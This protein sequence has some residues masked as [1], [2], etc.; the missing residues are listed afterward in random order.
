MS[1][2][3]N[4]AHDGRDI[5]IVID[6]EEQRIKM[7]KEARTWLTLLATVAA[8]VTYQAGLNPPS[9][10]WQADD[11][12]GHHAGNPVLRDEHWLRY[13]TFYYFNTTAFVTSLAMI[14]VLVSDRFF[15]RK[16]KV[17][18][19]GITGCIDV[20]SLIGAY[21][22]GSTLSNTSTIFIIIITCVAFVP[23]IYIGEALPNL[24]Y[25]VMF[26]APPLFWL[27]KKGWLP[28]TDHMKR[29]VEMAKKRERDE[30]DKQ[31]EA[32]ARRRRCYCCAWGRAYK[33][34][35][36]EGTGQEAA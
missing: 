13:Q 33:Y 7:I 17:Y 12:Q 34:D 25:V 23:I 6:A 18:T 4:E 14:V 20:A 5:S 2:E 9:G 19:L 30:E 31:A 26:M 28:V 21:A 3:I 32:K 1:D 11:S 29:R 16:I 8:S 35:I 24:C 22:A 15:N 36:E 10:F 27:A